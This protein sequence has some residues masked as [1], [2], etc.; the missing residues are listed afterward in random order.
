MEKL[1]NKSNLEKQVK[2]VNEQLTVIKGE[3]EII[4]N[5][6]KA[7]VREIEYKSR[8]ASEVLKILKEYLKKNIVK[9]EENSF[10]METTITFVLGVSD[11]IDISSTS[12]IGKEY[13]K[14]MIEH[15][16]DKN[17]EFKAWYEEYT[18]KELSPQIY[19]EIM[20]TI[21]EIMEKLNSYTEYEF[22]IES[23]KIGFGDWFRANLWH[24]MEPN[25]LWAS[26]ICVI[27]FK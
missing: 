27:N 6:L 2:K 26:Y 19:Q 11:F 12:V 17:D 23:D 1:K 8:I 10:K 20:P 21:Q 22:F 4:K 16:K 14:N 25:E 3:E 9:Y 5:S 7:N 13:A 18:E 24:G 15:H